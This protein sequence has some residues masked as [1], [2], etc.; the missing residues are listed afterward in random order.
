MVEGATLI[1]VV[2]GTVAAVLAAVFAYPAFKQARLRPHLEIE[3][4]GHAGHSTGAGSDLGVGVNVHLWNRGKGAAR[5]W[6]LEI[7]QDTRSPGRVDTS[8]GVDRLKYREDDEDVL[9]LRATDST[10]VIP[11]MDFRPLTWRANFPEGEQIVMRCIAT[12]ENAKKE[13]R[14]EVTLTVGWEPG[15]EPTIIPS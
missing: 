4:I 5:N 14:G 3:L 15:S 7:R 12:A 1:L 11:R 8:P 6:R 9:I 2:V 10:D 13:G